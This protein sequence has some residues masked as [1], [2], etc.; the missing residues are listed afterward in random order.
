M[1]W[2]ELYFGRHTGKS[3]PQ[4]LFKD[5][6]WFYWALGE[7]AFRGRQLAEAKDLSAKAGRVRVPKH[8]GPN[9]EVEYWVHGPTGKFQQVNVVSLTKPLHEGP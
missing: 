6:D 9:M 4:V 7:G 2:T 1:G 3:L 5:P 8:H